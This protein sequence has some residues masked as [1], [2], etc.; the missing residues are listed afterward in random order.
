M[1]KEEQTAYIIHRL[2]DGDAPKDLI[3]YLCEK[4]NLSWP[5]AEALVK[6]VQEE[7]EGDIARKQFP[8]LIALALGI[9]LIGLGLIGYSVYE[10]LSQISLAAVDPRA[11]L[12]EQNMDSIQRL[13]YF[14]SFAVNEGPGTIA[15]F[16]LGIAMVIGSLLGMRD[17]WAKILK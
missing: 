17:T 7:K 16:F 9:F 5:Q 15:T 4:E 1:N 2:S 12:I 10:T 11:E 14:A 3:F 13:Y 8:L 6:R